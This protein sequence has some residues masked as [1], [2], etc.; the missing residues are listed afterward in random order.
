MASQAIF[1]KLKLKNG[2]DVK[3][4]APKNPP[5]MKGPDH[6]DEILVESFHFAESNEGPAAGKSQVANV[7]DFV[8]TS[9]MCQG[10]PL[11]LVAAATNDIVTEAVISCRSLNSQDGDDFLKITLTNGRVTSYVTAASTQEILPHD[12]YSISF[13]KIQMEFR[14][15]NEKQQLG[16]MIVGSFDLGKASGKSG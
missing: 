15:R 4:T 8:F 3:G 13:Q 2:G 1:L 9:K 5:T 7:G 6:Q 10:S 16:G 14:P 11:L 12:Q